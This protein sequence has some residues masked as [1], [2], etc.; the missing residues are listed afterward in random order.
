MQERQHGRVAADPVFQTRG[1]AEG[2]GGAAVAVAMRGVG[3]DIGVEGRSWGILPTNKREEDVFHAIHGSE[4]M[5]V[6]V[7]EREGCWSEAE[8]ER[9]EKRGKCWR[10]VPGGC[11][12]GS[13]TSQK[14][15]KSKKSRLKDWRQVRKESRKMCRWI[16]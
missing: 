5:H 7:V 4:V 15:Q 6:D 12:V 13:E 8:D 10:G 3:V 16:V 14:T 9:T 2:D 11:A 1:Y